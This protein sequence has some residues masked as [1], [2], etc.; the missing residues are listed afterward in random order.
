MLGAAVIVFREV[1]EAGLIIG[2]VLALTRTVPRRGLW[3]ASG[4]IVASLGSGLLALFAETIASAE[5]EV[6]N[7]LLHLPPGPGL[8]VEI[9]EDALQAHRI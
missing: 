6:R 3:V 9:D 1:I 5:C 2:I 8:G 7:G 4:V